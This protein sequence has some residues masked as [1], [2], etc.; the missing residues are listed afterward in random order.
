MGPLKRT[1][2]PTS[3]AHKFDWS[4]AH[5]EAY[6]KIKDSIGSEVTITCFDPKKISS[7]VDASRA[8]HS[9]KIVNWNILRLLKKRVINF[10]RCLKYP[11]LALQNECLVDGYFYL[12]RKEEIIQYSDFLLALTS[13]PRRGCV[14]AR[15]VKYILL[16]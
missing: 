16:L 13:Y 4:P 11:Y 3:R 14:K 7:Q 12:K 15:W 10:L 5:Q 2:S 1:N 9:Y 6:K 8:Q